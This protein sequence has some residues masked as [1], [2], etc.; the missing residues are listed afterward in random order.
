MNILIANFSKKSSNL[1]PNELDLFRAM[2]NDSNVTI[3][4]IYI[5]KDWLMLRGPSTIHQG[6]ECTHPVTAPSARR[7]YQT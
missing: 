6:R 2:A 7:H 5:T 4:N 3:C 1:G